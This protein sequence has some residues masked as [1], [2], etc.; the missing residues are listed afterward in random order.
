VTSTAVPAPPSDATDLLPV[1]VLASASPARLGLLR[2]AGLDPTVIVSGVDEEALGAL[3]PAEL[4]VRLAE[5]K[6]GAVAD[7]LL[8]D[9]AAGP[10]AAAAAGT[11][12]A[13][14][15]GADSMLDLDGVAL[16]KPADA[17]EAVARWGVLA[18]RSGVLRTGHALLLL[19]GGAVA[20][21]RSAQEA[22]T[23][24]FVDATPEEVAAYVG[25]GEP[26]SC[27]GAFTL[28]GRGSALIAGV[29]GDPSSV[30]G[31][32]MPAV[33]RC[34]AELGAPLHRWWAAAAR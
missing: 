5:A 16:G 22:T 4:V 20:D 8:A 34:L 23:V 12:G 26:L 17:A 18:G 9:P 19:R 7:R 15:I 1:L 2:A 33:R 10:A 11:R 6:A 21:S 30:I 29:D 13:V 27:A 31:L 32:S 24:R 14:V 3:P 25:T 28:D